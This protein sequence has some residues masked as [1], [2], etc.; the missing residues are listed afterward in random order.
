[1]LSRVAENIF[2][3]SRYIGALQFSA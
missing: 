1:M 2:W 3:M